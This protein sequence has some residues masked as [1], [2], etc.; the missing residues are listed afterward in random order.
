MNYRLLN[1]SK[2]LS[3]RL[4]PFIIPFYLLLNGSTSCSNNTKKSPVISTEFSERDTSDY[5]KMKKGINETWIFHKYKTQPSYKNGKFTRLDTSFEFIQ[6]P[7]FDTISLHEDFNYKIVSKDSTVFKGNYELEKDVLILYYD[8]D[9]LVFKTHFI[10]DTSVG[11]KIK[12]I[13]LKDGIY[14]LVAERW[15]FVFKRKI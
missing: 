7:V 6:I 12:N 4:L 11:L 3:K 14:T 2:I 10:N 15:E 8:I 9:T 5:T 13:K 1:T